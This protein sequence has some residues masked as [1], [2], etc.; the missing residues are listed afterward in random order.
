[1]NVHE[2]HIPVGKHT[3]NEDIHYE[4]DENVFN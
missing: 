2:V 4:F 3:K 1:M